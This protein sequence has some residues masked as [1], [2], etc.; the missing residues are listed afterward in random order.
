M[1]HNLKTKL[2]FRK[3]SQKQQEKTVARKKW[4]TFTHFSPLIRRVT[5]L[6]KQTNLK[7]AFRTTNTIKQKKKKKQVYKDPS[8]IYKLKCNTCNGVYVGQ[9][10]WALNVRYKEHIRYIRTNNPKSAYATHILENRHEYGT[11]KST[12]QLL[13]A[14]QKETRMDC[15]EAFY[16]QSLP[17]QKILITEQ[18]ISDVNP[19]FELAKLTNTLR[20]KP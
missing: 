16:I 20:L 2:I 1:I 17:Q 18:Q 4:V 15:W 8:R 3:Q 9:S 12:L 19:L 14:C 11:R 10:G 13:Q 7:V 6:F 5:N